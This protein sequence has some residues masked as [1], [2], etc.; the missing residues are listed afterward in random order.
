MLP[1]GTVEHD[2][3][4]STLTFERR[5]HH[6]CEH[7]WEA[8]ATPDGLRGWLLCTYARIDGF[9]GGHFDLVSGPSQYR[10]TGTITAW[11]PP[12]LLEFEW[13]VA[14]LPEMPSGE[15]AT[16][17]YLLTPDGDWT[18]LEVTVRR[19]TRATAGGFLPG[20][21]AF[22]DRLESQLDGRAPEDWMA[23]FSVVQLEYPEWNAHAADSGK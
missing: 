11:E 14:P 20:L 16:F 10:S 1:R 2:G 4:L 19:I 22:L 6:S 13:N 7:V 12:R 21:H 5:Y 15:R 8:I 18:H 17:R 23:R 3:E 9:T